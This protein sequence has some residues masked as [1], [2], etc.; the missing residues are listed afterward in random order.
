MLKA[1]MVHDGDP[2]QHALLIFAEKAPQA[3]IMGYGVEDLGCDGG[4]L[5]M[6]AKRRPD[7]DAYADQQALK[8]YIAPL[9]VMRQAGWTSEYGH[10]CS[11]CGLDDFD[12]DEWAVC[13]ECDRCPECGHEDDCSNNP[14]PLWNGL[15]RGEWIKADRIWYNYPVGTKARESWSGGHWIKTE[16]GW[17]WHS[18]STFPTPGGSDE[19]MLPLPA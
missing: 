16:A 10:Q 19:V 9:A 7:L 14:N 18:G 5:S 17:K 11:C 12:R 1:Y 3:R 13:S 6:V 15:K 8:P 4:W 2:G